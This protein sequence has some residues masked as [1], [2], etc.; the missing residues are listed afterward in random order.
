MFVYIKL[1]DY[2]QTRNYIA[3]EQSVWNWKIILR[4]SNLFFFNFVCEILCF[5]HACPSITISNVELVSLSRNLKFERLAK[6][7]R[8][9]ELEF[10]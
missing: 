3:L 5:I 9:Y 10:N 7:V 1:I 4:F 6:N 2:L 8:R